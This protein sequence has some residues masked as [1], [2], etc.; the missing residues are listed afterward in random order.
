[1]EKQYQLFLHF[2]LTSL[3]KGYLQDY[4][5]NLSPE[6]KLETIYDIQG[7]QF[8]LKHILIAETNGLGYLKTTTVTC[9]TTSYFNLYFEPGCGMEDTTNPTHNA[10]RAL[11]CKVFEDLSNFI[12]SPLSTTGNKVTI[13][14]RNIAY[15]SV[16]SGILGVAS[17]FYIPYSNSTNAIGGI[18]DGEIWKTIHLGV[19]SYTNVLNGTNNFYHDSVNF[20][21]P[22]I[23]WNTII[24]AG[25]FNTF[26]GLS[27][28]NITRIFGNSGFQ[29][30]SFLQKFVSE[31]EI[32]TNPSYNAITIYPNPS[33]GVYNIDLSYEKQPSS[34]AIY[35]V[36]GEL[37]YNQLL[38]PE[39]QNQINL[40]HLANG[41]C[42]ARVNNDSSS[43]QQKLIKN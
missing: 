40:T 10:R 6:G 30:R 14:V 29:T 12:S 43:T 22:S 32:D 33:N 35:N 34:I 31:P 13:W 7:N 17:S 23:N 16:P 11:M 28:T 1:M 25:K 2:L 42:I 8:K 41:Y 3:F 4:E 36:L 27:A 5:I 24:V 20:N 9:S 26:N 39:T 19:D 15:L 38:T 37:L 21:D 18:L